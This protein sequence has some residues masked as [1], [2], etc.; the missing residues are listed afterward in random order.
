MIAFGLHHEMPEE[1]GGG[2]VIERAERQV[3]KEERVRRCGG[4]DLV[5]ERLDRE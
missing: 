3:T 5:Q 1:S 4:D 2:P